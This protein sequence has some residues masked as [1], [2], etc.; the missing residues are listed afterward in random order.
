MSE[1]YALALDAAIG[2]S[3]AEL[4]GTVVG[5]A[6]A[7]A[8]SSADE[9][10][11]AA[12]NLLG[13]ELSD[14]ERGEAFVTAALADLDAE[15]LTFDPLLPDDDEALNARLEALA[16]WVSGFLVGM[17][18]GTAAPGAI[19]SE[20]PEQAIELP[21][22]VEETIADFEAIAEVNVDVDGD[23]Q[24]EADYVELVEFVKAAALL[25]RES[26]L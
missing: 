10:V 1:L 15:A 14:S 8:A 3:V 24:D 25:T 16:E 17:R 26:M 7:R 13:D 23:E 19:D 18:L 21:A 2:V 5:L 12:M 9:V 6:A 22:E 4:H 11:F 20:P